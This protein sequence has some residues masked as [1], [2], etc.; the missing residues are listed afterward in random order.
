LTY[1]FLRKLFGKALIRDSHDRPHRD[2]PGFFAGSV[3]HRKISG[4][5][6][7]ESAT[8]KDVYCGRLNALKTEGKIR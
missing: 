2:F 7:A 1:G 5:N 8:R 4:G 6:P 3:P